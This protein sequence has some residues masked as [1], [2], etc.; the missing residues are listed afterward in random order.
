MLK[1]RCL[2]TSIVIQRKTATNIYVKAKLFALKRSVVSELIQNFVKIVDKI[3]IEPT[4]N[5]QCSKLERKRQKTL[6]F[7]AL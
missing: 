7:K 1:K 6:V 5:L 3:W 4:S 2:V